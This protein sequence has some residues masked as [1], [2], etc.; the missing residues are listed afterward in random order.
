[1]RI[2]ALDVENLSVRNVWFNAEKVYFNFQNGY[3]MG[4]PMAWFARL[5]NATDPQRQ[6]WRLIGRGYGVNWEELDEDLSAE[7]IF[8]FNKRSA[9]QSGNKE[10][11]MNQE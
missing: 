7:G 9:P 1:M 4:A 8:L 2:I 6:N 3:T 10:T 11:K 5:Q